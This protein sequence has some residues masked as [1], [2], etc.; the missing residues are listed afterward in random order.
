MKRSIAFF[1]LDGTI[2]HSDTLLAF[3][4]YYRGAIFCYAGFALHIP[5]LLAMKLGWISTQR[6]KEMILQFFFRNE[7]LQKFDAKCRDFSLTLLPRLIRPGALEALQQHIQNND[8]VVIVTASPGNWVRGWADKLHL[9]LI[10]TQ[11]LIV[12]GK[13]TGKIM[14]KNCKGP[15]KL[16]RIKEQYNL[17][18]YSEIYVYG[19]SSGDTEMF[20]I[21]TKTFYKPFR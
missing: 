14:G 21:G 2:T 1:D 13:I 4:R 6:S 16:R 7:S 11:L 3:I 19:D 10:A 9:K 18:D 15:E 12:D 20:T 17:S 5:L 8:E